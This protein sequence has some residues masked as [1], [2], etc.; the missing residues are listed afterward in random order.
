MQRMIFHNGHITTLEASH[1]Q[2][3]AVVVENGKVMAMGSSKEMRLEYGRYDTECVDLEGGY[4]YPGLVDSHL[5]LSSLGEKLQ[6]LDL[7]HCRTKKEIMSLIQARVADITPNEWVIG[8][9]WDEHRLGGGMPT[10]TELDAISPHHPVFLGRICY[11]AYL[12]NSCAYK[13]AGVY[14]SIAD[15]PNGSYGRDESGH[16]N[17]WIYDHASAPFYAVQPEPSYQTKKEALREA[18]Q[19]ALACG[20]TA[21]HTDDLRFVKNVPDLVRIFRE[22]REEG[23]YLRTHH[24]LYH[25]YLSAYAQM[26]LTE[27]PDWFRIGAVKLFAD[28]A[29]GGRTALL[30]QPY[31][32]DRLN[33]GLSIHTPQEMVAIAN[34]ANQHGLPIAVH[35]IGDEATARVLQ[36]MEE[37][38]FRHSGLRHR[39]IHGQ[40]LRPDL[41]AKMKQLNL[42]VDIQPRFVVSDFPWV[43]ERVG[44]ARIRYAYAWKSL[45]EAKIPCAGGS[46]APIEPLHPLWGM[47]AAITRRRIEE[48]RTHPGYLPE[49]KLTTY[50]ALTLFTKGSSYAE[51]E[52]MRRGSLAIGKMADMS[53][54]DRNL[55]GIE[56]DELLCAETRFTIANGKVAYRIT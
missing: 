47:H 12:V 22:L 23:L 24:L 32:D 40:F 33:Y 53:V 29:I 11:H 27:D 20:L 19:M 50:E 34:Q 7:T 8:H 2:V 39:L 37:V 41:I 54:Y 56:V 42:V 48:R 31:A 6:W 43:T 13:R 3:E 18:M 35:A 46:D 28:G 1:P 30:S 16:L 36:V 38:P 49:Q 4:A 9:G 51:G 21:V 52:E 44:E 45:L 25:P 15:P 26:K 55:L 10:L 5:H 14:T 17:G